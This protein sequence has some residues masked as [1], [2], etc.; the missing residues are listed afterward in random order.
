MKY[1]LLVMALSS[2][3]ASADFVPGR[4]RVAA[5]AQMRV[6]SASGV[7]AGVRDAKVNMLTTDGAQ[8]ETY[9]ISLNGGAEAHFIAGS[10]EK[11]P[12]ATITYAQSAQI[13][14]PETTTSFRLEDG[15]NSRCFVPASFPW[16]V[17]IEVREQ[18]QLSVL[19]LGGSPEFLMHTM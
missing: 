5:T 7:F 9:A 6:I 4:V 18:N 19:T 12:C 11:Q 13:P 1:L 15:R 2:T 16:I 14:L 8:R 17:T 10:R 3:I